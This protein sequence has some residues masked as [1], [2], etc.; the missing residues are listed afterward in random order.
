MLD[1]PLVDLWVSKD[2]GDDAHLQPGNSLENNSKKDYVGPKFLK[3]GLKLYKP[4]LDAFPSRGVSW[5]ADRLPK[6]FL[7]YGSGEVLL[8]SIKEFETGLRG[9]RL[10]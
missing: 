6:T 10:I 9:G 3:N 1:S 7:T 4:P 5:Y 2:K 8:D